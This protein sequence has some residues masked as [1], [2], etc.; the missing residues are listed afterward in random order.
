MVSDGCAAM[1]FPR[2]DLNAKKIGSCQEYLGIQE[3]NLISLEV[4]TDNARLIWRAM[5][6]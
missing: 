2:L 4:R 1:T 6:V 5:D 3:A